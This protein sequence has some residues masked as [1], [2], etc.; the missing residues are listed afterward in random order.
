MVEFI[1]LA[2]LQQRWIHSHEE[3]TDKTMVFRP[4]SFQFPPSRGR[5]VYDFQPDNRLLVQQPGQT[6]RS[7]AKSGKWRLDRKGHIFLT[8]D[9][10]TSQTLEIESLTKNQLVLKR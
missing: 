9:D 5:I 8:F 6:D 2:T 10:S 3:D 7:E 1:D 4:E